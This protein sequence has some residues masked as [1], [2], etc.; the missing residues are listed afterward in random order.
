MILQLTFLTW[1]YIFSFSVLPQV[2]NSEESYLMAFI[3]FNFTI[4]ITL[5]ISRFLFNKFNE[6]HTIYKC[7]IALSATALVL[8]VPN[9]TF[10][11]MVVF[12]EGVFF[13]LGQLAAVTYFWRLTKTEERGR[14]AG[15]TGFFA[16][17]IFQFT[18]LTA[19]NL[20]Y[21]WSVSLCVTLSLGILLIKFVRPKN[22]ALLTSKKDA[23]GH[24][25]E[26]RT[27]LLYSLPWIIFS[28]I[29]VTLARNVSFYSS[30]GAP[31]YLYFNLM[32]L[33]AI[34]ACFGAFVGGIVSDLF[35]RRLSLGFTLTLYGVSSALAGLFVGNFGILAFAYVVNGLNWGILWLLYGWTI[36]GDLSNEE[37][38]AKRYSIGL[39]INFL[40]TGIGFLF[41]QQI[42]QIS[43]LTSSLVSCLMIFLSNVPI[44][45]ATELV[46]FDFRQKIKLR[47]YM[48]VVK[49]I[50]K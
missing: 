13:G 30:Q 12:I 41:T 28:F 6:L 21:F 39:V 4:V 8:F 3:S 50:K 34:S 23:I 10:A 45:I 24:N 22:R 42:Y 1:Y 18:T 27:V 43:L 33:Q 15:F 29:N 7:S 20:D 2:F 40:F 35:G 38:V 37:N 32:V 31:P 16:L 17:L 46:E 5:L 9:I 36:W 19:Q 26:K 25:F 49:K 47:L 14:V 48:N 44:L 11:S